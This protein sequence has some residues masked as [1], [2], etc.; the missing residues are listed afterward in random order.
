MI[1]GRA[2]NGGVKGGARD[3]SSALELLADARLR[4]VRDSRATIL[5]TSE[6]ILIM[7]RDSTPKLLIERFMHAA[8]I[9]ICNKAR[10]FLFFL[11]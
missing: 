1:E 11:V 9:Q 5:S 7:L 6:T 4:Q 3:G 8:P 2:L 10:A